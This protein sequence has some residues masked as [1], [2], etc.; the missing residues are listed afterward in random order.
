MDRT[1]LKKSYWTDAAMAGGIIG[2]VVLIINIVQINLPTGSMVTLLSLVKF[3][4][5]GYLIYYYARRRSVKYDA[6]D[7]FSFGQSMGY[8]LA[9][10]LFTGF[11]LGLSDFVLGNYV[12][13]EYYEEGF[14]TLLDNNPMYDPDTPEGESML[15]LLDAYRRSPVANALGGIFSYLIYGGLLGLVASAFVKRKPDIFAGE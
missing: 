4:V 9:M 11:I 5:F 6:A 2:I 3:M 1:E 10:M 7:G 13:P 8:I 14:A 12:M 15:A